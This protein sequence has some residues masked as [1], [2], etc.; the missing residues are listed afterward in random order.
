MSI[1][2]FVLVGK[3]GVVV[4]L[5]VWADQVVNKLILGGAGADVSARLQS[6]VG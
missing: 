4:Y 5:V 2:G 1:L 6:V 3:S